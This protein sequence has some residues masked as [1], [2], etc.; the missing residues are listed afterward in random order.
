MSVGTVWVFAEVAEGSVASITLEMLAKAREISSDVVAVVGGD[1]D[2]SAAE[3]GAHGATSVLATGDLGGALAGPSV[4]GAMAAAIEGG[5]AP[6]AIMF[7]TTYG[8]RD[9]AGRLSVKLD[10]SVITNIVDLADEDGLVGT[11]PIFGGA[12]LVKTKFTTD[13]PGIFLIRPKSFEA[14]ETGGGAAAVTAI[15]VP[16]LGATGAAVVTNSFVEQTE[17]P[18]LDEAAVVVS[19]GRGLGEADSYA[20]VESLASALSAAP[21]ASRAIVDAGWVPYSY[22]VGQT[23]KVVKPDVYIAAGISGATQ[24]LVGM[25]GSK[26]IIAINKDSEAPI[27]GVADLGIVG[28]VHK[29][30]PQLL[31]ALAARA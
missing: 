28:D 2:A 26:T 20:L 23:G 11:E 24:H 18:K 25:K 10:A 29:V 4:A 19:G 3:L 17:G 6:V 21:G 7:G 13:K 16:D 31:E 9:V 22:Q 30:L 8:G 1:G 14:S 15:A 5:A 27:F 12:S